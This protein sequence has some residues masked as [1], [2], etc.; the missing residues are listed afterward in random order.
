MPRGK[1]KGR[2]E[3]DRRFWVRRGERDI[4][5]GCPT[6]LALLNDGPADYATDSHP[7]PG[8][9]SQIVPRRAHHGLCI[10]PFA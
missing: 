1:A 2:D 4:C 8:L 3:C 5:S 9:T 6:G 10:T 7:V